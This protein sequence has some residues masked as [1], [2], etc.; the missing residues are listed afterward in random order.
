MITKTPC[1][2]N[3]MDAEQSQAAWN[4]PI[5]RQSQRADA[6]TETRPGRVMRH[7]MTREQ[8][9][10]LETIGHAVDYLQDCQI[11]AGPEEEIINCAGPM[12]DAIQILISMHLQI[13]RSLPLAEPLPHRIW[14]F[15]FHGNGA[16]NPF[17]RDT[18]VS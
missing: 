6:S 3:S 5:L 4:R 14:K 9:R 16:S 18:F 17:Q 8:G 13:L 10:A 11:H 2:N 1:P 7:V 12:T 15:F